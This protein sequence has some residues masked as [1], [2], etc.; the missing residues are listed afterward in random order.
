MDLILRGATLPDGRTGIDIAIKGGKIAALEAGIGA[1]AAR[2]IDVS[3]RL[4]TPPF[5]DAHFHMDA[6]LT[7]GYPRYNE[8]G[9]LL[10]GIEL[11]HDLKPSL[12]H[13][14]YIERALEY[15]DWAVGRGL[16]AIRSHVDTTDP[17]LG[18]VAALV[19]VREQV[20][21]YIDLQ[22][23]AFPQDGY[24]RSPIGVEN[25]AKALD[26]GV[27]VVGGIPHFERTMDEGAESVRQL[28]AVAAERG[29]RIDMHCDESDDPHSRH[30]ETL[31]AETI[32]LGLEGRVTGSHLS[33]MHSMDNYYVSKLIPL[34]IEADIQVIAN[35]TANMLLM[36]R[37]DTYPKRRGM[38]R[39]KE[40]MAAGLNVSFGQ[41]SVMDP[42]GS[43]N[44]GDVLDAA[45]MAVHAGHLSGRDEIIACFRAV[46]ENPARAMGLEGYG[47]E[48]GCNA[49]LVV[50]QAADPVEA[51]RLR[52]VR[53]YVMRRGNIIAESAPEEA[54]LTLPGRPGST[55][56]TRQTRPPE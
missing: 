7:Y 20:K 3:G 22:L 37:H 53:L 8:S 26:M 46:T 18:A 45:H 34:M 50:L 11:W 27:D 42:W 6:T 14:W 38:T 39:V 19:E 43:L 49:D 16:L 10:E 23:V 35:P 55:D 17:T 52:P 33:S 21:D 51:V 36:G 48:I 47:L 44:T 15:C 29:L 1:G 13:D 32:R 12:S 40:L 25:L 24:L 56:F 2:E 28:C 54:K 9:T 41:D 4:V 5:I 31:A 30:I